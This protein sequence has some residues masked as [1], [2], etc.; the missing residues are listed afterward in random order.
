M[1]APQL[2]PQVHSDVPSLLCRHL[3]AWSGPE[4]C[5]EQ[6]CLLTHAPMSGALPKQIQGLRLGGSDGEG[7]GGVLQSRCVSLH[8]LTSAE[9]LEKMLN[10]FYEDKVEGGGDGGEAGGPRLLLVRCD[11]L[12]VSARRLRHAQHVIARR[13]TRHLQDAAVAMRAHKEALERDAVAVALAVE[14]KAEAEAAA[15]HSKAEAEAEGTN[16]TVGMVV[17]PG[18]I[19][20]PPASPQAT[21]KAT[22]SSA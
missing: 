9:D 16:P 11:Y 2:V 4:G 5:G 6:L 8:E 17:P 14:Q 21:V 3:H 22:A 15:A 20:A 7:L 13:H 18:K 1:N 10:D 19:D 12:A